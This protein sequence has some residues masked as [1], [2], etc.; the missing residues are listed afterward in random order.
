MMGEGQMRVES[1]YIKGAYTYASMAVM[2]PLAA[3]YMKFLNLAR[4][5]GPEAAFATNV[6]ALLV[7][8]L[9]VVGATLLAMRLLTN[10]AAPGEQGWR[11]QAAT[12]LA[13]GAFAGVMLALSVFGLD[14]LAALQ[15]GVGGAL[16]AAWIAFMVPKRLLPE[17]ATFV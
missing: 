4:F 15:G 8:V 2:A 7:G 11:M 6:P 3:L 16:A 10:V 14:V 17:P 9:A 13:A 1:G 5:P 12:F